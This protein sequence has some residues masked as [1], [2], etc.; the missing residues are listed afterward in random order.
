MADY[1]INAEIK[2]DSKGFTNGIEKAQKST[3]SFSSSLTKT[4]KTVTG[5]SLGLAGA[6]KVVKDTIKYINE[7]TEAY[8]AEA[9]SLKALETA[10]NNNPFTNGESI[11]G[12]KDFASEIQRTTNYGDDYLFPFMQ[13]LISSG[14]TQAETMKIIKVATDIASSGAMSFETAIQQLNATMNGNIGRLGQ[15]NAELKSLTEE[16]LRSGEAVEILG[17]KYKGLAE[18]T[19]DSRNS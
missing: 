5:L 15:Q 17:E 19:V 6:T 10:V 14:R 16:Q 3:K 12:L 2:A 13:Q 1:E 7:S 4:L 9:L 18:A 11:Q 8:K